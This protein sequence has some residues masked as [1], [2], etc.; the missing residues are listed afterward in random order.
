MG[1]GSGTGGRR[2]RRGSPRSRGMLSRG[3]AMG[4]RSRMSRPL[5]RGAMLGRTGRRRSAV[6]SRAGRRGGA[7]LGRRAPTL[8]SS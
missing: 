3:R 4:R 7:V 6:F 1:G 5:R 8:G 2:M